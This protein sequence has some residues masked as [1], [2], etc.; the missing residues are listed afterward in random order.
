MRERWILLQMAYERKREAAVLWLV[1]C[2]P[3]WL[4]YWCSIRM[5]ANATTGV[6]GDAHPDDVPWSISAQRWTERRGGDRSH[7][8]KAPRS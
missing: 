6:Y 1:W 5:H 2:L 4:V 7:S 3:H 8:S